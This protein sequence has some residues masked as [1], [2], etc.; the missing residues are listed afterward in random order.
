MAFSKRSL[1]VS[2]QSAPVLSVFFIFYAEGT[3]VLKDVFDIRAISLG[4]PGIGKGGCCSFHYTAC[5]FEVICL[6]IVE[7]STKTTCLPFVGWVQ[8]YK[9][10][11]DGY[12]LDFKL[13][14]KVCL[15]ND[16][17]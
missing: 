9:E 16:E 13:K 12:E 1:S 17:E 2:Q 4:F 10:L 6:D 15:Y 14:P 8:A 7:V 5:G 11:H 3:G